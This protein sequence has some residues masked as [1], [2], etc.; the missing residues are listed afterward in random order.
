MKNADLVSTEAYPHPPKFPP[1]LNPLFLST[2]SSDD[3]FKS[4]EIVDPSS[5]LQ[6]DTTEST[7]RHLSS[8][9]RRDGEEV[10]VGKDGTQGESCLRDSNNKGVY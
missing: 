10:N 2:A 8:T 9:S 1:S 4:I 7:L 6:A 3:V 5:P